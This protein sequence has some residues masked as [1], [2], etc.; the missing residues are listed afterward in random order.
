MRSFLQD[1]ASYFID[2]SAYDVP[3]RVRFAGSDA[4]MSLSRW[5]EEA[6][7]AFAPGDA[8]L[9]ETRIRG[10]ELILKSEATPKR[11][12]VFR[13]L[14]GERFEYDVVL[15]KEPETNVIEI[16]LDFPE[17]LEFFRQPSAV[18]LAASPFRCAPEVEES[19]AV[20]WKERNGPYK[21]G[22]FCHI[23]R[24][25]IRDA[26]GRKVWGRLDIV[27]HCMTITI[28]DGWLSDAV[29]PVVV[30]PIVGTQ[31]RGALNTIDW[32]N[33]DSPETFYL[34]IKMGFSRF[35]AATPISGLCNSYIYSYKNEADSAQAVLFSDSAGL[36]VNRLSRNEQVVQLQ[37]LSPAWVS[38]TFSLPSA[39][40]QDAAFWYGYYT[41]DMLY[42]Y[43]DAVG[44]FRCMSVDDYPTVPD[45]YDDEWNEQTWQVLMSAYFEYSVAQALN[46]S[47]MD[48]VGLT[49]TFGKS[50][51]FKRSCANGV[52]VVEVKETRKFLP[53][54]CADSL[55]CTEATS[56]SISF[57][58]NLLDALECRRS[59]SRIVAMFRVIAE[60]VGFSDI[61][62]RLRGLVRF[63]S[64]SFSLHD[65]TTRLFEYRRT[66]LDEVDMT[67]AF[68]M[69]QT[70][71][72]FCASGLS[73][74]GALVRSVG[75]FRNVFSFAAFLERLLPRMILKKEELIIV[76]RVTREIEFKGDLI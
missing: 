52:A 3:C 10:N 41:H 19:Y 44:T 4:L 27:G 2:Q 46:R 45:V 6:S 23:Y 54:L 68:S 31:T 13:R 28:P 69:I 37:R 33:E 25:E 57:F 64:D 1:R 58:R 26:R 18:S 34:E 7:L 49:E 48:T 17:G 60:T 63:C 75:F 15:L 29:Y 42:T 43:Y 56:R 65:E 39:V 51:S 20:Y 72:R 9:G 70:L 35:T 55:Q 5:G 24:P 32:Y 73:G 38:S 62:E 67:E 74:L 11:Y 12:H 36:P 14:D 22:K 61:L 76:S 59:S 47:V 40:A 16:E 21:T 50:F 66:V 30:D 71:I 53:R 8:H